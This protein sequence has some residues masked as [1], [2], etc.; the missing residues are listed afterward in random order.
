MIAWTG[1]LLHVRRNELVIEGFRPLLSF[2]PQ[3]KYMQWLQAR[4]AVVDLKS[5]FPSSFKALEAKLAV[6]PPG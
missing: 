6:W 1:V 5:I 4:G 3:I 2:H